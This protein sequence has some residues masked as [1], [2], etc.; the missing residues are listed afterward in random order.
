MPHS[1]N[2]VDGRVLVHGIQSEEE[3]GRVRVRGDRV[4]VHGKLMGDG[5]VRVRDDRVLV[6]GKRMG[7]GKVRV[8]DK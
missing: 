2:W 3:D 4:R 1:L 5:T 6:H 7:D 8:R